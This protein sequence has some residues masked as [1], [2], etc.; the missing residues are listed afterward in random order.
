MS[1]DD[2]SLPYRL[3]ATESRIVV[4][5]PYTAPQ[6]HVF[7]L[8]TGERTVATG[9]KGAGPGDFQFPVALWVQDAGPDTIWVADGDLA[10]FTRLALDES[11]ASFD[12]SV[13]VVRPLEASPFR[14]FEVMADGSFAVSGTFTEAKIRV[15][16]RDGMVLRRLGSSPDSISGASRAVSVMAQEEVLAA[17]PAR[18]ELA[19]AGVMTGAVTIYRSDGSMI[20]ANAPFPMEPVF[21][22]GERAGL[23][24]LQ[25]QASTRYAYVD[26][27][28]DGDRILALFSG[29]TLGGFGQAAS[30]GRFVHVFDWGG[31]FVGVLA[32]E[33]PVTAIALSP[34]GDYL[35]GAR[36]EPSP[37]VV[38]FALPG[39]PGER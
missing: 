7:D 21:T 25:P 4:L 20:E 35:Y 33:V 17:H 31:R 16:D 3:A 19:G 5:S 11:G 1:H 18:L 10:R 30:A 15:Y 36:W 13:E 23:P 37:A 24:S 39:D 27:V 2:L 14:D 26:A 9:P 38:R 8:G 29:R 34:K 22:S 32:L 6:V 12:D 28:A